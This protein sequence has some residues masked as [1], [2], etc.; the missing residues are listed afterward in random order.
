VKVSGKMIRKID[1]QNRLQ[2]SPEI[3]NPEIWNENMREKT[4]RQKT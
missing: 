2:I 1:T 4:N 3:W